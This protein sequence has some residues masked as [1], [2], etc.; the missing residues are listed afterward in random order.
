MRQNLN[1]FIL[2]I[3]LSSCIGTKYLKPD[4]KLITKSAKITGARISLK[5]GIEDLVE[6]QPNKRLLKL[7][8]SHLAISHEIGL[9]KFDEQSLRN[10]RQETQSY[11]EE[12]IREAKK[13]RRKKKLVDKQRQKTEKIDLRIRE[14][15]WLMRV[16]EKLAV[17]DTNNQINSYE[18]MLSF[19]T[20]RG[21]FNG[22]IELQN[23]RLSDQKIQEVYRIKPGPRFQIDS[24]ETLYP[25]NSSLADSHSALMENSILSKGP[26]DQRNL[27]TER[28]RIFDY[29]SNEGF[30]GFS[31]NQITFQIDS[32]SLEDN[33]LIIS[34]RIAQLENIVNR[35]YKLDSVLF[36]TE[37]SSAASRS[38]ETKS[39]NN[40]TYNFGTR[41]YD[42]KILD[43]R[44]LLHKDSLFSRTSTLET[45]KQLSYLD[46]FRFVNIN[47]DSTYSDGLVANIFTN[48]LEKYQFNYELGVLSETKLPSPFFN[49]GFKNRN[50]FEGME[51][52]QLSGTVSIQGIPS[53]G[54]QGNYSLRNYG[55]ELSTIFP[56]LLFP[57][58]DNI[59]RKIGRFN[60]KTQLL[61]G[62]SYED[63]LSEYERS[64][65]Q[66][67]FKYLWG[68]RETA[69]FSLTPL[70]VSFLNVQSLKPSFE[71]FLDEQSS[72]GNGALRAAFNSS[73]I[74]SS[75][76]EGAFNFNDY[77]SYQRNSAF[78]RVFAETG[79]NAIGELSK[80]FLP[81]E[82][83]SFFKWL[84]INADFRALKIINR[85]SSLAFRFNFG[86]GAAYDME[87]LSLPYDKRFYAG[88]SNSLRGWQLRRLGPGSYGDNR[89]VSAQDIDLRE[90]RYTLE[91]GGDMIM[92]GSLEYRNKLIGFLDYAIF[93]DAG[94]I[95]LTRS[96]H[97]LNDDDG[98]DGKFRFD[99]FHTEIAANVGVGLRMDFSFLVLR[100]DGAV[101]VFDPAQKSGQRYVL[102]DIDLIS[103]FKTTTSSDFTR[104]KTNLNLGIG[105]PF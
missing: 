92:E 32:T 63:R 85:E 81:E 99:T 57:N 64:S 28:Q 66:L 58:S 39:F 38:F 69:Q 89:N 96:E 72:L 52:T 27:D 21:Y 25:S 18:A 104:N 50:T 12:K 40:V 86:I 77:S 20:S 93:I 76:F 91:Q 26:Y 17:Y 10:E 101:Q 49:L 33:K 51:V 43:N 46:A 23:N 3:I 24:V 68:K 78:L 9:T 88:G 8:I 22:E 100:L 4:E 65:T 53:V 87:E 62:F 71:E 97:G 79:G 36:F 95:W 54:S 34:I 60:P 37:S 59:N 47:F 56:K 6:Q 35:Q 30:Y 41:K 67:S 103:L 44:I 70:S 80:Q 84:K 14:G 75:S 83:F 13:E 15:N 94:N 31:K 16:G 55:I 48:P 2:S 98:D 7:P 45:Q 82:D 11:F 73:V 5:N 19:L 29:L 42:P 90:I 74:S 102:D 61:A 1:Y 105:F